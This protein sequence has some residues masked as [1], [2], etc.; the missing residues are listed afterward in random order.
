MGEA[1]SGLSSTGTSVSLDQGALG[2]TDQTQIT[3]GSPVRY[4]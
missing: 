1:V 4:C 3:R 2:R